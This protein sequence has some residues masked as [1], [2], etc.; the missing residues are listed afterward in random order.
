[1]PVPALDGM[2][3]RR[4]ACALPTW[5]WRRGEHRLL[6]CGAGVE[7][8]VASL[9]EDVDPL[10][11]GGCCVVEAERPAACC[12]SRLLLSAAH[13]GESLLL[14]LHT[15]EDPLAFLSHRVSERF[16]ELPEQGRLL[17]LCVVAGAVEGEA[18]TPRLRRLLL[19]GDEA[20][21]PCAWGPVPVRGGTLERAL[22]EGWE[23]PFWFN[24]PSRCGQLER[25]VQLGPGRRSLHLEVSSETPEVELVGRLAAP[26]LA[27]LGERF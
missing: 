5:L 24:H 16:P 21:R 9:P 1:M 10:D 18:G 25:Q 26:V 6:V 27:V 4:I 8:G 13:R 17:L 3:L 11:L 2:G 19:W 20:G 22:K 12:G 7:P 14:V 23:Q 15:G